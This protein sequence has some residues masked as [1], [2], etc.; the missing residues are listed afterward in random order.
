[1]GL[2][3]SFVMIARHIAGT[4][5]TV[6]DWLSRMHAYVSSA[7]IDRLS[8]GHCEVS[9]LMSYMLEYPGLQAPVVCFAKELF[10]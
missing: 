8:E 3:Q 6:A 2:S 5:N 9:C 1:M 10:F 7:K 4:K